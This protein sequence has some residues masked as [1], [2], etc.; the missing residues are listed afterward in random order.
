MQVVKK[1]IGGPYAK[2]LANY[3][4]DRLDGRPELRRDRLFIT[5]TPVE[6][7]LSGSGA[8]GCGPVRPLPGGL[9]NLRRVHRLL[10]LRPGNLRRPLHPAVRSEVHVRRLPHP[11]GAGWR[12]LQRRHCRPPARPREDLI[13]PRLEAYRS[14][15][16]TYLRDG[17]DRWGVGRFARDL[18]GAYGII[19]R[20][21]LFPHL[22][23][24]PLR[25]L[26]RPELR[27]HG[28][29]QGP[30]PG[31]PHRGRGFCQNHD[32]RPHGL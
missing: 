10:P 9:R 24:G 1:N 22:Q 7:G 20:T 28:S 15:G 23:A 32:L 14:L 13:R 16:F 11:Y 17:G 25:R 30:G 6:P 31:G 27:H 18:A 2:C 19:Y 5:Y 29:V 3:V 21:P 8:R 4:K 12:L 26:H